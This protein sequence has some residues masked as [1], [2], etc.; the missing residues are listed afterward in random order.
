M[1]QSSSWEAVGHS[2]SQEIPC[3]LSWTF[4]IKLKL[5][6]SFVFS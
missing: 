6:Y 1:K 3:L 2:A 4:L 5:I